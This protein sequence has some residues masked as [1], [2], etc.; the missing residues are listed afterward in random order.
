MIGASAAIGV[1]QI[2]FDGPIGSCRIAY[3]NGQYII[4]PT[5]EQSTE[6][7]LSMVVS[8]SRDAILM[9]EAG[10]NEVSEEVILEAI[11]RAQDA[12]SAS[13]GM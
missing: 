13:I 2:P 4:H 7:T 1:S 6:S 5:Y 9:V 10:A 8:S 12:N 11:S 3:L